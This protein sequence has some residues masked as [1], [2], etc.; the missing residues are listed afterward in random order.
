MFSTVVGT[1][2]FRIKLQF[3]RPEPNKVDLFRDFSTCI[4]SDAL[5]R[6]YTMDEGIV[7][8]F[9]FGRMVGT[10]FTVK[11][12][13]G[14][15]LL[16]H[17]SIELVQPG[18]VLV[19]DTC[20][21]RNYSVMGD[22]VALCFKKKGLAGV[23]VDGTIRDITEIKRLGMPVFARGVVPSAGDKDGPGEINFPV[24]CGGLV[25]NPGDIIVGDEDG[26]VV[27]PKNDIDY[28][29]QVSEKKVQSDAKR[30]KEIEDGNFVKP[31]INECL[32]EKG[33][34]IKSSMNI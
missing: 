11:T 10:A 33:L 22:L 27:I 13:P 2:G 29:L 32:E 26:L 20:G 5:K 23:V 3:E 1:I 9:E 16:I 12:R 18:D 30:L 15:N 8:M 31:S 21:C 24:V 7:P 25:V 28:V 6:F 14:D 34:S 19:V 17:K 4:L